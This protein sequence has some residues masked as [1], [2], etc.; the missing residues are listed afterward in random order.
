MV[1]SSGPVSE[2]ATIIAQRRANIPSGLPQ[3][4]PESIEKAERSIAGADVEVQVNASCISD[5]VGVAV[6]TV[7]R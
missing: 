6:S 5:A 1:E 4:L 7:L 2:W 3:G